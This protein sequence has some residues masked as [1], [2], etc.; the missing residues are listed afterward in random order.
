VYEIKLTLVQ[1]VDSSEKDS[2]IFT[3]DPLGKLE[4]SGELTGFLLK[5]AVCSM[6]NANLK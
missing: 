2:I 4:I 1:L 6:F 5:Q 3:A